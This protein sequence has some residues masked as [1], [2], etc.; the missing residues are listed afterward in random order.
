MPAVPSRGDAGTQRLD[1]RCTSSSLPV[2]IVGSVRV[3]GHGLLCLLL[4]GA[5][6]PG[7]ITFTRGSSLEPPPELA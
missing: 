7:G 3:A 1:T 2:S 6:W 4:M 5:V